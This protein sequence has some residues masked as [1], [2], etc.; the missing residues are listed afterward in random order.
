MEHKKKFS[1]VVPFYFNEQ[2]IPYTV[3]KLQLVTNSLKDF[4]IEFVFI[5]D[6]SGDNTYSL[7]LQ[8]STKDNRIKIIKLSRNFGSMSAILAG[9][10]YSSGDCI[11]II[12]S[13]LQDPPELFIDMIKRWKDGKKVI[14]AVRQDR[15]ESFSQK[16]FA[17]IFYLLIRVFALKD[18]PKGGFDFALVDRSVVDQV[19]KISEKNTNIFNL[20]YWL[21]FE[22]DYIFYT[23]KKRE[24][25]KSR[26]TFFK[27][28]KFFIDSFIAFSYAPVRIISSIG[29]VVS[30]F[31]LLFGFYVIINYFYNNIPV[32]GYTAIV[33]ILTF[34]LGLILIILGIIGE[35]LWRI[36]DETRRRPP[37]VIDKIINNTNAQT[38]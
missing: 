11:G 37:F 14:I 35:Y 27:K 6:G 23:R 15:E 12:T 28:V 17:G 2:N 38:D 33:S 19:V 30:I 29:I 18:Y 9:L 25:G 24:V 22:R 20:I 36:L 21:G 1:I 32:E 4:D 13:D 26:W 34:L 10:T 16:L 8:E 5:D 3:P 7:L 31:S